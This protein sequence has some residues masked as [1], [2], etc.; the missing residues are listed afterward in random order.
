[1]ALAL[2]ELNFPHMVQIAYTSTCFL[3]LLLLLLLLL[4]SEEHTSVLQSLLHLVCR[5]LP[6]NEDKS[7]YLNFTMTHPPLRITVI[8]YT[9]IFRSKKIN[10]KNKKRWIQLP[11]IVTQQHRFST[12]RAEFSAYGATSL[13]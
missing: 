3:L 12:S 9:T 10:K 8:P 7:Q 5:P 11:E 2:A 6:A 13:Y 1:M 4:R